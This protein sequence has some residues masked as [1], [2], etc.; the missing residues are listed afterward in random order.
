MAEILVVDGVEYNLYRPKDETNDFHSMVKEHYKEIFG[1]DSLYFDVR[2]NLKSKSKIGSIPDAYILDFCLGEW[3]VIEEEL[4]WHPVYDHIV[5]QLT[6]FLNGIRN[7][8]SRNQLI[9]VLYQEIDKDASLRNFIKRQINSRDIHHALTNLI[10]KQP[11]IVVI[12]EEKTMETEEAIESIHPSPVVIEFKTYIQKDNP[13]IRAHLFEPLYGGR[14]VS[15]KEPSPQTL[16]IEEFIEKVDVSIREVTR[17]LLTRIAQLGNVVFRGKTS[18]SAYI[19]KRRIIYGFAGIA[20]RKSTLKIYIRTNSPSFSDPREWLDP[21]K[22]K[23]F[24]ESDEKAFT[25]TNKDQVDYAME[26][27]TQSYQITQK[28]TASR[29]A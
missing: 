26:L 5:N 4:S 2:K 24:T 29:N 15:F 6:R 27:I 11:S 14:K 19:G 22:A 21:K 10:L 8:R 23:W 25:I 9:E 16:S 28:I 12:I 18:Y 17:S 7:M 3:Y 20:P 13:N 1:A